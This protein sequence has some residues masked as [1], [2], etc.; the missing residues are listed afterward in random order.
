MEVAESK[1]GS[2]L[3]AALLGALALLVAHAPPA[4]ADGCATSRPAI[5][6]HPGGHELGATNLVPCG[7][8]TGAISME[9]SFAFGRHGTILFQAWKTAQA[10]PGGLPPVASVLRSED[11]GRTW[12]DVSPGTHAQSFDPQLIVDPDTGRVYTVDW[13]G[14]GSALC[15]ALSYSDDDGRD[16]TT[17]PLACGGFDGESVA[18]GPPVSSHPIG[19]PDL[20]Y[21]CT[22]TTLGSSPPLSTPECSKSI[23]GGLTFAPTGMPPFPLSGAQDVYGPWAGN[24]VVG[25]D[26][27]LFVPKRYAGRPQLA[28]SRDEGQSWKTVSV[29]DNGSASEA[30]RVAVDGHGRLYY[31]WVADDQRPYLAES[32]HHGR[33]WGAPIDLAPRGVRRAALPVVGVSG[34]KVAVAYVGSTDAPRKPAP[35]APCNVHLSDCTDGPYRHTS[36]N[37]YLTE[38]GRPKGS[39]PLLHTALVNPP[40][41]PLFVGGCAPEGQ[42]KALLDFLDVEFDG[43]GNPWAAFVDDC[44]LKRRFQPVFNAGAGRCEDGVGEGFLSRLAP[45]SR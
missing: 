29:A 31:T 16:W 3:V 4:A 11:G 5:A 30:N 28:I 9:P 12:Q 13:A 24:P 10:N 25:P 36:W 43:H 2:I 45:R 32:T 20:V 14:D 19:Y 1:R 37:G 40:G 41:S 26:G 8:D 33:T 21:Y 39:H 6:Y 38:L 44:K 17:S 35:Y 34:G 42:C 15:A 18:A 27:T 22:G 7:F 23:D